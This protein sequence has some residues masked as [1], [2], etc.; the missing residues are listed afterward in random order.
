VGFSVANGWT[1]PGWAHLVSR[2]GFVTPP[3]AIT[4]VAASS[5]ITH[6]AP[7]RTTQIAVTG[8]N[9]INYTQLASY[10]SSNTAKAKVSS[11]G[12]VTGVAAGNATIAVTYLPA[13]SNTPLTSSVSL[14]V[15]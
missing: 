8:D 15:S 1:G 10:S 7:G 2:A 11:N 12:L 13:G 14:T 6:T 9:G 3:T 5:T 4:A